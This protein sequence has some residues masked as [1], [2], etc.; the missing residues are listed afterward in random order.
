MAEL[1]SAERSGPGRRVHRVTVYQCENCGR[2]IALGKSADPH[3]VSAKAQ[4]FLD[5]RT[6]AFRLA[7]LTAPPAVVI[8]DTRRRLVLFG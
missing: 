1:A 3:W 2:T 8:F 6:E 7:R 4:T 5:L